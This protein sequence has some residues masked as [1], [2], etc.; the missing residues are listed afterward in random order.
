MARLDYLHRDI[1]YRCL[2]SKLAARKGAYFHGV[3]I[4]AKSVQMYGMELAVIF[5]GVEILFLQITVQHL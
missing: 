1:K 2:F 4:N 5:L 3:L